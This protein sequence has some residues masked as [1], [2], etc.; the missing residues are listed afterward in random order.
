MKLFTGFFSPT[1]KLIAS[2]TSAQLIGRGISALTTFAVTFIIAHQFG[3]TGY[4]DFVKVTTYAAFF[5]LITDFGMNA[6]FLQLDMHDNWPALVALRLIGGA[7]LIIVALGILVFLPGSVSQGYTPI[8]RLGIL[9]YSP[10]ILLQGIITSANAIFQKRLRYDRATWAILFGSIVTVILLWVLVYLVQ[11][12]N[13]IS[14]VGAV[15]IGTLVTATA[16]YLFATRFVGRVN[17]SLSATNMKR[18]FIPSIPLGITLLFNLVY[19]RADSVVI[20][21]TRPTSEVG[22]YG[23]A[24]KVFEVML[25][26]PTFFMNSVYPLMLS[27]RSNGLSVAKDNFRLILKKSILFL[28]FISLLIIPVMWIT[29]PLIVLIKNDFSASIPAIRILVLSL[30]F[31]YVTNATMW[32]LVALKKQTILSFVYGISMLVNVVGNILLVPRFGYMAAAW[33][34]VVGE[35]VVL[36]WSAIILVNELSLEKDKDTELS[37]AMY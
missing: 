29:A 11:T 22:V 3:A 28:L 6:I 32:A 26:L 16:S 37:G 19:F 15:G 27:T 7:V 25:V 30:P 31:F 5:Y 8:V 13:L 33:M 10:T 35:G 24:Y 23:L 18:L 17:F 14:I 2:N 20:T 21:L 1:K 36:L 34:T 9:L 4:G 12:T